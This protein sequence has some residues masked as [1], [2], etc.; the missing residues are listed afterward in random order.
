MPSESD[1]MSRA[2]KGALMDMDEYAAFDA[3]CRKTFMHDKNS[4]VI[5]GDAPQTYT[6]SMTDLKV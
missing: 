2:L 1:G 6:Y 5:Y 4:Q 3:K